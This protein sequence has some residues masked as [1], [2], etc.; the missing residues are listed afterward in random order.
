MIKI[1]SSVSIRKLYPYHVSYRRTNDWWNSGGTW[2]QISEW[3]RTA[4]G[5]R[6]EYYDECFMFEA[7]EHQTLFLLRWK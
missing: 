7:A 6:W 4:I 2:Y 3:C 5:N 1:L